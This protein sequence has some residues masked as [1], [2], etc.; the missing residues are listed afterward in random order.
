MKIALLGYGVVGSGVYELLEAN[1]S[2]FMDLY[3][4]DVEIVGILVNH[5][6]KYAHLAHSELFTN[7]FDALIKLQF[8]VA[9]ETV[10]G[11]SP[12]FD[13]VKRL[14]E[15]GKSVITSNKDL[16]AEK[17]VELHEIAAKS[18]VELSYEASVCGGIPL[19]KPIRECLLGDNILEIKGIV[20]GTTNFILTKMNEEGLDYSEALSM[21]QELGF[22]EA[23]PTSDVEGLDA[24]RKIAILSRVGLNVTLD[25]KTLPVEGITQ[26]SSEDVAYLKKTGNVIKLIGM[27]KL[28]DASI[29]A[30]VRPVI[31]TKNAKFAAINNEFN[32]VSILGQYVGELFLSGKGAG[33]FPT[34]TAVLGDLVDLLQNKK[35]KINL[36][37]STVTPLDLYPFKATW[38]LRISQFDLTTLKDFL[39]KTLHADDYSITFL[40]DD[41]PVYIELH[42]LTE[43]EL[44]A[45]K[46]QIGHSNSK[47]YLVL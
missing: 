26:I 14:L 11:I 35:Q 5:L 25:W 31:L 28:L 6:D 3:E 15:A 20:N 42:H 40:T 24:I 34:A 21:A 44:I 13:Y 22:A 47:H 38:I 17:G 12:A 8:D 4:R 39:F 19:L 33:K 32:G 9:I 27:T 29:Y 7:S 16:I 41:A 2:K 30:A 36:I 45:L 10:G 1:Q 23:D 37:H 43:P 18:G 46:A